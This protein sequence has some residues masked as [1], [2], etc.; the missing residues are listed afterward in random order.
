[1]QIVEKFKRIKKSALEIIRQQNINRNDRANRR[2]RTNSV[3]NA[4]INLSPRPEQGRAASSSPNNNLS[5]TSSTSSVISNTLDIQAYRLGATHANNVA[6]ESAAI[7]G[8]DNYDSASETLNELN[9][10]IVDN[11][12]I[13]NQFEQVTSSIVAAQAVESSEDPT[14][15][16]GKPMMKCQYCLDLG[17]IKW[18]EI[19]HGLNPHLRSAHPAIAAANRLASTP[20]APKLKASNLVPPTSSFNKPSSSAPSALP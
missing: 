8:E 11:Q 3:T 2:N 17:T 14:T 10:V 12:V 4:A 7:E 9:T 5:T 18:V 20:Q 15:A 16:S 19:A 1:M 6:Q 13:D